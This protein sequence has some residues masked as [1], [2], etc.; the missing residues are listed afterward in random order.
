[1]DR[2]SGLCHAQ[3]EVNSFCLYRRHSKR[4]SASDPHNEILK[5]TG[6]KLPVKMNDLFF[7]FVAERPLSLGAFKQL[8]C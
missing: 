1:M 3:N 5:T 6:Y 2:S 8:H 7:S 4:K